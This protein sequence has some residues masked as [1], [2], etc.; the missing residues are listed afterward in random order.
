MGYD[1]KLTVKRPFDVV[2]GVTTGNYITLQGQGGLYMALRFE[3]LK[4]AQNL[5]TNTERFC[6]AGHILIHKY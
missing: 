6:R 3:Y 2:G 1:G 4:T 5:H